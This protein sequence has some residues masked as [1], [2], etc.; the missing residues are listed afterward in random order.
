MMNKASETGI[1]RTALWI[2]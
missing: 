2:L 1:S